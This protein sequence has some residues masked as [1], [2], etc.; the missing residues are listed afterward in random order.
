MLLTEELYESTKEIWESYLTHPFIK[1]IENGSLD[2]EK[3]RFYMVQDYR[4]LLEY[5]KVFAFGVIKARDENLM[6]TFAG[7]VHSILDGEMKIHKAYMKRLGIT[8]EEIKDAKSSLTNQAYTSYMIDV[9]NAGDALDILVAVL[10]CQW[11]YQFIGEHVAKTEGTLD[12]PLFGEWVTGYS[13]KEFAE[14]TEE[15]IEYINILGKDISKEKIDYLKEI[16]IN[17]SRFEYEFWEMAYQ[18]RL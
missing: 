10:S 6:R 13:S 14:V 17:C 8:P 18:M 15:M 9:A 1:G 5:A 16:F 7:F 4:Y 12:H 3:F 11:S 2:K